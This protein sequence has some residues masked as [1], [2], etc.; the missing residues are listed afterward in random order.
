MEGTRITHVSLSVRHLDSS[1][2]FYCEVFDLRRQPAQPPSPRRCWC[3]SA[4]DADRPGLQIE[5]AEGRPLA[6]AST[7]DHFAVEVRS[8]EAIGLICQ[9]VAGHNCRHTAPRANG[10]RT[11]CFIFDPDGHKIGVFAPLPC[12]RSHPTT[13][14]PAPGSD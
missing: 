6:A 13:A 5:L 14:S 11:A 10:D 4:D 2:Q 3:V 1:A 7:V 9:R 12:P 8:P